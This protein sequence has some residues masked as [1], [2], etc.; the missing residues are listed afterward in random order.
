MQNILSVVTPRP[1]TSRPTTSRPILSPPTE[2]VAENSANAALISDESADYFPDSKVIDNFE[3]SY[4]ENSME[5]VTAS[6]SQSDDSSSYNLIV[7]DLPEKIIFKNNP[8]SKIFDLKA[9]TQ[10]NPEE[11]YAFEE[12]SISYDDNF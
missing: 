12:G 10:L 3:R 9:T 5:Y 11:S 6:I 2:L 1:S 8:D 7:N 4:N